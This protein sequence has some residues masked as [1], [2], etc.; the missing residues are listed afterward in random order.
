VNSTRNIFIITLFVILCCIVVFI[1][2][3]DFSSFFQTTF[4]QRLTEQQTIPWGVKYIGQLTVNEHERQLPV[5]VAVLDSGIHYEHPDFGTNIKNGFNVLQPDEAAMD[6][7][8]HGTLVAG[9]IAAQNNSIGVVGVAPDVELYPVKVLNKFGEGDVLDILKGIDWCIENKMDIMNMSFA[10]EENDP[11]LKSSIERAVDAGIIIVA[12]AMNSY[13]G[14]VGYPASYEGVISVTAVDHLFRLSETAPRGKIDFAAPG[15]DVLSTTMHKSYET[16]TGTSIAA[17]HIT[18]MVANIL[19][20]P[21]RFGVSKRTNQNALLVKEI[22]TRYV[23]HKGSN[24][25][26]YG[27]GV[28]SFRF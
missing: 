14:D 5:K 13:G 28:T 26:Q 4:T 10:I 17:P 1:Y 6:D 11:T 21:E 12:S 27:N 9:V 2:R 20:Q 15:V 23:K 3:F 18:G 8:G 16:F 19:R 25:S 24:P 7:Y 22:L